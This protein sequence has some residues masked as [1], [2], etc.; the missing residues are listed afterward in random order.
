MVSLVERLNVLMKLDRVVYI[1][2]DYLK[3]ND[4]LNINSIGVQDFASQSSSI[5][6]TTSSSS[7]S[8]ITESW[9]ERICE[10]SYQVVDHFDFSREVVGLSLSF[11]DRFLGNKRVDKQ[12]F[13]LL[14]MTTLYLAIKLNEPGKLSMKSMVELSR[15]FFTVDDMTNMELTLLQ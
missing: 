1:A 8:T 15:G 5:F 11:L 4:N 14:A 7:T 2:V 6:S 9:R 10:W 12:Q 3:E 13:Q